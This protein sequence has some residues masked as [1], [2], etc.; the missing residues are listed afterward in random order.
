MASLTLAMLAA[1]LLDGCSGTLSTIA[2]AAGA[3]GPEMYALTEEQADRVL[4]TAMAAEF[5]GSPVSRVE[6]PNRGY[7]VMIRFL[8]DSQTIAAVMIPAKGRAS[9]GE[10]V[11]SSPE[12]VTA[13]VRT[14]VQKELAGLSKESATRLNPRNDGSLCGTEL[15]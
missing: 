6:L 15:A 2:P 9:G 1:V 3:R 7:Q 5:A 10:I 12:S 11:G 4:A 8:L 14:R 13:P